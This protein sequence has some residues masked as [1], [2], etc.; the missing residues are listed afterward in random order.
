ML[1]RES[2]RQYSP[3]DIA[4]MVEMGQGRVLQ[5]GKGE[6]ECLFLFGWWLTYSTL[7]TCCLEYNAHL[8]GQTVTI[9]GLVLSVMH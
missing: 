2:E 6:P 3:G 1:L 7:S 9:Y 5:W 4:E 8:A